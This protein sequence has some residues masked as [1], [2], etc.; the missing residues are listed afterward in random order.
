MQDR[1]EIERGRL[2]EHVRREAG[3]FGLGKW[4]DLEL[5]E[6]PGLAKLQA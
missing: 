4:L 1:L 5:L 3:G 2:A 6:Q